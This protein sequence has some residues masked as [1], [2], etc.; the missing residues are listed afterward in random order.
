MAK[1]FILRWRDKNCGSKLKTAEI[2]VSDEDA[3]FLRNKIYTVAYKNG[4]PLYI[5][6]KVDHD[7]ARRTNLAREIMRA[8]DEYEVQHVNGNVLDF[9]RSNLR[10]ALYG[11]ALSVGGIKAKEELAEQAA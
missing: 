6:H 3:H 1:K 2:L 8:S 5:R 9:R 4:K 7:G 10:L 11:A